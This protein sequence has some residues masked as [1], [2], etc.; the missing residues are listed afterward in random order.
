MRLKP[1]VPRIIITVDFN[2]SFM[3]HIWASVLTILA[4]TPAVSLAQKPLVTDRP[5]FVESSSTVDPG[6]LQIEA[7]WA[8]DRTKIQQG[9]LENW[10][11]PILLRFGVFPEVEA[12]LESDWYT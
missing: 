12:R 7:S 8:F 5:D 1:N 2:E 11:T 10:S 4:V 6:V 9:S 3:K